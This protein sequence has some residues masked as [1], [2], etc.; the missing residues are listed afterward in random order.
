MIRSGCFNV[1]KAQWL[2]DCDKKFR[3]LQPSD[4]IHAI[5]ETKKAF[6]ER[7]YDHFEDSHIEDDTESSLRYSISLS[8]LFKSLASLV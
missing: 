2:L 1:A 7:Q 6:D 4:M 8:L 3:P 5:D